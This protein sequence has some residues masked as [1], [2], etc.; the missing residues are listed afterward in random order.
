MTDIK[1]LIEKIRNYQ[2]DYTLEKLEGSDIPRLEYSA[3]LLEMQ[4]EDDH[5][6]GVS[7]GSSN[8]SQKRG[9]EPPIL[10]EEDEEIL[11]RIWASIAEEEKKNC[12]A[13]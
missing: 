4:S 13:H 7:W 2:P 5:N 9:D 6:N 10:D 3:Q 11:D 8:D 1:R 12:N